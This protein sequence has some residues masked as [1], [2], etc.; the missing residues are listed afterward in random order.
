[1]F[2]KARET[3]YLESTSIFVTLVKWRKPLLITILASA[4]ASCIFSSSYFIQPK[5]KSTV[6]FFPTASTS[7]SRAIMDNNVSDKQDLLAFG[8]EEQAEQMLQ[9]LNSDEIRN[10]IISKYDLMN[11]YRIDPRSEYPQTQLINEFEDNISFR[12][13]EY[14]SIRIDVLDPDPKVAAGIANDIAALVDSMKTK[15]QR[16]RAT[17]ALRI[18]ETE[19]RSKLAQINVMED[20][21]QWLRGKGIMDYKNQSVIWTEEFAK[22]SS[23]F[24]NET[25][26]LTVLEKY[27]EVNDSSIINTKARIK[28]AEARMKMMQLKLDALAKFGGANVAL[29]DQLEIE[30]KDL[31]ELKLQY[32]KLR[33]DVQQNLPHK[34]VVNKAVEAEKKSYPIRWLIV[35]IS[36]FCSFIIALITILIVERSKEISY[37]I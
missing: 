13:T 34:F 25:A 11:H 28:G 9:I 1:M 35:A 22:S 20:S 18:M 12:Q 23:A 8:E 5:Y 32:D 10:I 6:I 15:I 21:L 26:S 17:E 33:V 37:R 3:A 4:I 36:V 16:E 27:H 31:N 14:L 7:I 29:S 24:T 19:Y 30:R 2:Q